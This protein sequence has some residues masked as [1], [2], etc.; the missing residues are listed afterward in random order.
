[1]A[2]TAFFLGAGASKAEGAPLPGELFKEHPRRIMK[3]TVRSEI[4]E[5]TTSTNETPSTP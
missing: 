2:Y 4:W 5:K 3:A 1:M